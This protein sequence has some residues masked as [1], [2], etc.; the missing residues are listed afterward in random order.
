MKKIILFILLSQHLLLFN[1]NTFTIYFDFDKDNVK[2]SYNDSLKAIFSSLPT[3]I[4]IKGYTDYFGS[5]EYNI[6]LSNRRVES[7]KERL[8]SLYP[9]I[10]INSYQ[11]KGET[12]QF[13]KRLYNRRVDIIYTLDDNKSITAENANENIKEIKS[14]TSLFLIDKLEV[15]ENFILDNMEFI[16]G[17]HFLMDYSYPELKK[18]L[19]ALTKFSK[20]KIEIQGHICCETSHEDGLDWSTGEYNLSENRAKYVYDYL[21]DNGISSDRLSYKGFGR[22]KPLVDETKEN[23]Q[24]NR[25]VEIMIT[26]K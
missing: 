26:E 12:Q 4:K 6:D 9:S 11:G 3:E 13:G 16:P 22:T 23:P 1:Q 5:N 24:R 10:K 20:L 14:D 15:G 25:R 2:T 8:L 21:I 7:V 17:E 18:L 19:N